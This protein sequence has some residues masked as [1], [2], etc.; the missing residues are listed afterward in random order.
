M[1]PTENLQAIIADP[2]HVISAAPVVSASP[3]E[4]DSEGT[5]PLAHFLWVIG[6]HCWSILAFVVACVALTAIVSVRLVPVYEAT[7]TIDVDRQIPQ[8]IIGAEANR[9]ALNDAD[10]FLATQMELIE[11]DS[12]L[13]PVVLRYQ[14]DSDVSAAYGRSAEARRNAPIVLK[15][16]RITRPANTYLLRVSYRS[17]DADLAANVANAI[18]QSYIAQTFEL[19]FR[20]ASSQ[21]VF[22]EKQIE[23]L[24]AKM[25]RS[26]AALVQFERELNFVN[27]EERT[28]LLSARLLQLN[29]EYTASQGERMK[30]EAE[31]RTVSGSMEAALASAQ[32]ESLRRLMEHR[33]E[34]REKFALVG[35][36]YG[37]NHP[38][39]RKAAGQLAEV[40]QEIEQTRQNIVARVRAEFQQAAGRE[41]MLHNALMETKSE[42]DRLNARS[43]QYQQLKRE[44]ETDKKVYEELARRIKEAGINASFQ[45]SSIRLADPARPPV[46][47]V[48]PNP[49]LNITL[50]FAF[51][52]LIGVGGAVLSDVLDNTV[53]DPDEVSRSLN[54]QVLG[55]LP[56]VANWRKRITP[57]PGKG[58]DTAL[59]QADDHAMSGFRESVRALRNTILLA[60]FDRR[61]RSILVTSALPAE[62]KSTT[63]VHL[64]VAHA[65]QGKKTLLVDGDLRRPS[66]HRKFGF[67]ATAGLSSV[68]LGELE[69]NQV[70][71]KAEGIQGLDIL[72]AGPS[73]RRASE[74]V[75]AR[76]GDL[77]ETMAP[78]YDLIIVDAP[79]MLGFAESM[80]MATSIDGV[81]VVARA[82]A[83]NRKALGI[84]VHSLK[85]LNAK[86]LGLVINEVEHDSSD[87]Y[88]YYQ[89]SDKYY[90][91]V[92]ES[93]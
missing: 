8:G 55:S 62:G 76:L 86:I 34:A 35:S 88:Y 51:S 21:S 77:L 26:S 90:S 36:Q 68:L 43:V 93:K 10:Q 56:L 7:A 84:V 57:T 47:P 15:K 28:S 81:L 2:V 27:A 39:Y 46:K 54:V 83:T 24:R 17:P 3:A 87:T 72:P 79:P 5:L 64:A 63:S 48:F 41:E 60:D 67:T 89:A 45:N 78:E 20:A 22:M 92:S 66:V 80:H 14:L 30:R 52:L 38:E 18:A 85:R 19:R 13:R 4:S 53:R 12:V 42:F 31:F 70:L 75:G 69:W 33:N 61:I 23:E 49:P 32:G 44:A 6:R 1:K 25:E 58:P 73:S 9:T 91:L 82:G 16:L 29:T 71:V 74:M 50:A 59:A 37:S 11:S 40:D 65:E